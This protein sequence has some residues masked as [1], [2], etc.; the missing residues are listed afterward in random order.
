MGQG[1]VVCSAMHGRW[2]TVAECI[3]RMAPLGFRY[4]YGY[5]DQADGDFLREKLPNGSLIYKTSNTPLW[6]KFQAG[7]WILEGLKYRAALML[8][9]D[10]YVTQGY[11]DRCLEAVSNGADMVA[12]RD[13][14]FRERGEMYYWPGYVGYREGEPAGAGKF[15]TR[16]A[17]D[18]LGHNLYSDAFDRGLDGDAWKRVQSSGLNVQLLSVQGC[19]GLVDI[20]DKGSSTKLKAFSTLVKG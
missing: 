7:L 6:A 17:M 3:E 13:I 19:K 12:A 2:A 18:V 5:S 11:V 15:Y 9:S 16:Q 14:W 8:G 20:K 4:V 10:D 1:I